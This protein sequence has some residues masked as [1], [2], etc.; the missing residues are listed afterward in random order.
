MHPFAQRNRY[1]C[2]RFKN[3][4]LPYMQSKK[5]FNKKLKQYAGL[6]A[7]LLGANGLQAQ[8]LYTDVDPDITIDSTYTLEINLDGD[9]LNDFAIRAT[10]GQMVGFSRFDV[11]EAVPIGNI[12]N[13][14]AGTTPLMYPY[15]EKLDFET[16]IDSS[17]QFL[18]ANVEGSMSFA[19]NETFLYNDFWNEGAT[20]KYLG[21]LLRKD[22][23]WHYGWARLD[24]AA[25]GKS[26]TLKDYAVNLTPKQGINT[27][28]FFSVNE[29]AQLG[30]RLGQNNQSFTVFNPNL[31]NY[32]LE[33]YD[34][35]GQLIYQSSESES[36]VRFLRQNLKSG[37]YLVRLIMGNQEYNKKIIW[38]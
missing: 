10:I 20:D 6:T 37:M 24:V 34:I 21:F 28:R 22:T 33:L 18:P 7:T 26:F 16:P 29:V 19:R 30:I 11:I 4:T 27:N 2:A 3:R 15:A 12:G 14:I 25:D 31:K 23:T 35:A 8:I 1:F 5:D 36:E 32:Q 13:R 38:Y 17:T 9:T